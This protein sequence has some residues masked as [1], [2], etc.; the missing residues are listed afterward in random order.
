MYSKGV[1]NVLTAIR[2]KIAVLQILLSRPGSGSR[3]TTVS[4]IALCPD[5]CTAGESSAAADEKS[6]W[7]GRSD[8]LRTNK[9]LVGVSDYFGTVA[10]E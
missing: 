1:P 2:E 7:D 6:W 3:Q 9:L 4:W 10:G 5:Q 8:A